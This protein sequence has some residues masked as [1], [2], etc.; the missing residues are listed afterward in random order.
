MIFFFHLTG[1]V[2]KIHDHDFKVWI[3]LNINDIGYCFHLLN[4]HLQ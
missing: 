2:N 1:L 3:Y 4:H